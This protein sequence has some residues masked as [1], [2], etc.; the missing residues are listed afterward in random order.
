MSRD[1]KVYRSASLGAF[2]TELTYAPQAPDETVLDYPGLA[3][4]RPLGVATTA[5]CGRTPEALAAALERT[6]QP[7]G[8]HHP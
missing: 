8:T 6:S 7:P 5:R 4:E 1:R 2:Y 3:G